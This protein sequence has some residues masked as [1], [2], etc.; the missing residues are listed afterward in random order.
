MVKRTLGNYG[1]PLE[2]RERAA[3]TVPAQ[4]DLLRA[5]WTG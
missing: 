2:K 4:A 3:G 5:D 1:Y